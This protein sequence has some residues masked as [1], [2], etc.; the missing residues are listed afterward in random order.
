[1][2]CSFSTR[3]L[4][5]LDERL[6]FVRLCRDVTATPL[7]FRSDGM[8]FLHSHVCSTVGHMVIEIYVTKM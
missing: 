1:M 8:L 3:N 5:D 2:E 4:L 7:P 6:L